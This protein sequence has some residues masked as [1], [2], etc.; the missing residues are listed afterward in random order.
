MVYD[1]VIIGAG[2]SGLQAAYSA[3][4]A[5]LSFAVV[6]ARD[7]PGGKVWSVPL[8]SGRGVADLGA[9]WVNDKLQPRIAAYINQFGLKTVK[10][11]IEGTAITQ[12]SENERV[13]FPF[14]IVPDVRNRAQRMS[15]LSKRNAN[16]F[17]VPV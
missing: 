12:V 7:R 5:G 9:A 1:V 16:P 4:Q 17:F 14:G 11:P 13:E 8:S 6:E 10:Q 15:C 3:K 2:M